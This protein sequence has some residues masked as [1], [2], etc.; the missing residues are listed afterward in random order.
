MDFVLKY[1]KAPTLGKIWKSEKNEKWHGRERASTFSPQ[2]FSNIYLICLWG[3]DTVLS[4]FTSRMC[5]FLL[6]I[7][8]LSSISFQWNLDYCR[9]AFNHAGIHPFL[10]SRTTKY[11]CSVCVVSRERTCS[12]LFGNTQT[13]PVNLASKSIL[14][15]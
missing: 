4:F 10:S 12:T 6:F 14:S 2:Y 5:N 13:T 8:L 9:H 15:T 11:V 3:F 7:I 1:M